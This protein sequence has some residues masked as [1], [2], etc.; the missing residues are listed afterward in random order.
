MINTMIY[1]LHAFHWYAKIFMNIALSAVR[2]NY[3]RVKLP[4]NLDLHIE[5]T[6]PSPFQQFKKR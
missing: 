5:K 6:I 1:A 4:R 3:K 2:D